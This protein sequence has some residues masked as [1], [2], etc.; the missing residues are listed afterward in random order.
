MPIELVG[1]MAE[2]G[3]LVGLGGEGLQGLGQLGRV[4]GGQVKAAMVLAEQ[5]IQVGAGGGEGKDGA[6]MAADAVDVL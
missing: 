4:A 6:T 1:I 3:D 5:L 2:G